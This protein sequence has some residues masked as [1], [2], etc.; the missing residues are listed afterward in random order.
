MLWKCEGGTILI[1]NTQIMTGQQI[2]YADL[3]DILFEHRNKKYGAYQLRRTYNKRL[4]FS[5]IFSFSIVFLL[6]LLLSSKGKKDVLPAAV[7]PPEVTARIIEI[8]PKPPVELTPPVQKAAG[9]PAPAVAQIKY[10]TFVVKPDEKVY[11]LLPTQDDLSTS[12]I[13]GVTTPGVDDTGLVPPGNGE[14]GN[15]AATVEEK[16]APVVHS[17]SAPEF[18]GGAEAW[19]RFL[20]RHLQAPDALGQGEKKSVI[21]RFLVSASGSITQ[22]EVLQSGGAVFDNE[23]IRVLKKMPKWK[24]ALENGIPVSKTFTQPVTFVQAEE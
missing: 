20:S 19:L 2:L 15:V 23:V 5:L 21:I 16:T 17:Y 9:A 6:M 11:D 8:A 7:I 18:P 24:P 22:F 13:A 10:N 1:A 3:L 14:S 12:A 4:I